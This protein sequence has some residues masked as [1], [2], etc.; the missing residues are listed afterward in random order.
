MKAG[1][2]VAQKI[3]LPPDRRD[4][5]MADG[6]FDG[7]L[8]CCQRLL[9]PT[10]PDREGEDLLKEVESILSSA[11]AQAEE[12]V[13]Q[14]REATLHVA[15]EALAAIDLSGPQILKAFA[16]HGVRRR[17]KEWNLL[18]TNLARIRQAARHL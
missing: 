9:G 7:A 14:Y 13:E 2:R 11:T 4:D 16:S 18:E 3:L 12:I 6:D 15:C 5:D 10:R 8:G 1:G 17:V